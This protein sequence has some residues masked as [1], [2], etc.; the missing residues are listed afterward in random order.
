MNPTES[1][2]VSMYLPN[3]IIV[4]FAQTPDARFFA[5]LAHKLS[6]LS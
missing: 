5:T 4:E 3:D 2:N 6:K 1:S